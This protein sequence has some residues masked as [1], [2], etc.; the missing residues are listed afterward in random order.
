MTTSSEQIVE[1]LRAA[2][3]ENERLKRRNRELTT[4]TAEPIAIVGISCRFPGGVREPADLW[5][6]VADG[7]DAVTGFPADRGWDLDALYSADRDRPGTTYT[8]SGGFL[9]G[10]ADFDPA[11][12]GISPREALSMDPQQRLL[13]EASWEAVEHARIDPLSLRGSKTGVFAG[14]VYHD[15]GSWLSRAPEDLEGYLSTGISG[16]V[17][18]G[19]ISYTLGLAGP[20]VTVDTACSSSLVALHL[21]CESL[22]RGECTLALAGGVAVLATPMMFVE[23]ARQGALSADG[24]CR[25]FA[26]GADGTALSE[27]VG[28]L[29]VERLSDARRRGHPVLA[30]VRGSAINQDGASSGLTAPNGPAQQ[31]VI[32][33]ALA[34]AGLAASDVDAV[35]AHGTGTRLGDPIE[36]QALLATYGQDR[37]ADRPLW[38]GSV[39]SNLGHTQA[40]AG[41]ASIVKLVEA[42]RHGVLPKSLHLD[43]PTPQVDWTAGA[44]SLL[45]E[46]VPWPET[47]RP[48]R[49]GVSSFGISGTNAHVVLEQAPADDEPGTHTGVVPWVVTGATEAAAQAQA[50]RLRAFAAARPELSTSD[51]GLSLL[52]TRPARD[53]RI[54]VA[55]A[56]RQALLAG[57]ASA[58][59]RRVGGGR[60]AFLFTGQGG[61]RPG[62]GRELYERYPVY[63]RAFDEACAAAG[64]DRDLVLGGADLTR[65]DLA[66]PAI[67]A[68]EVALYRLF[69]AWGARPDRLAG[70]SIGEVAAAHVAGVLSL[71]DAG[72]LIAAR[73]RLLAS[74]PETGAMV[75]IQATEAEVRARLRDFTGVAAGQ[76]A[77]VEGRV[78]SVGAADAGGIAAEGGV[79]SRPADVVAGQVAEVEVRARLDG[80]AGNNSAGIAGGQAAGAGVRDD[81]TGVVDI[82]AVQAAGAE[83]RSGPA[84]VAAGQVAEVEVRARLDGVAGNNSAGIAAGQATGA[85]VRDYLTGVVDIAA[86]NGPGSVVVS[87]AAEAVAA[88]A[89]HFAEQ[90]RRTKR[91]SV[92]H[93]FHSPLVEPVLDEFRAVVAS[94][95]YE[96]PRIPIVSTVSPSADL[97]TPGYWVEHVRATVRFADAVTALAEAGV[98]TCVELGPDAVLSAMGAECADLTFVPALR[99]GE[100]EATTVAAALG[101][102]RD[103]DWPGFFAGARTVDLPGYAFQRE[104]F[105]LEHDRPHDDPWRYRITWP[106]LPDRPAAPPSGTWLVL[107][108]ADGDPWADDIREALDVVTVTLDTGLDRHAV[109]ERIRAALGETTPAGVLSLLAAATAPHPGHPGIPAGLALTTTALQALRVDA[110][111]WLVTRSAVAV[112]PDEV[113]DPDQ[114]RIWGFGQVAALEA[115]DRDLRLADVA[116]DA[117]PRFLALL[118]AA[119]EHRLAA[120][121]HRLAAG[122]HRPAAGEHRPAAGR[123]GLF[124][125]YAEDQVAVRR[126]GVHGRRLVRATAPATAPE[127]PWRPRGT[128]LVTGG[129]GA[130]GAHVARWLAETGAAHLVLTSRRGLD[131]PGAPALRDELTALGVRVTVAACD[132]ADRAA[133]AALLAEHPPNAVVHAAGVA[134][135]T[136]VDATD[137]AELAR[138][139]A[140][141]TRGAAHLDELL[142]G[143]DLDAFVL[144]SSVSGVWGADGQAAYA[145]ANAYLDALARRRRARGLPATAIAWG[146]WGET[147]M[148]TREGVEAHLR[149]RGLAAMPPRRAVAAVQHAL[150]HGDT[151]VVVADVDWAAFT[152]G[153]RGR[154][155]ADLPEARQSAAKA[156]TTLAARLAELPE[157]DRRPFVTELVHRHVAAVLGHRAPGTV[158]PGRAFRELGFDSLTAVDLRDRLNGDTGLRLSA[159]VVFDH[160]DVAALAAELHRAALGTVPDETPTT[161]ER[162]DEPI[163][164]IGVA[165]RFP[166]GADT[167]DRFWDLVRSGRDAV[168]GFPEDR[169]WDLAALYDPEPG[170]P[171][172]TYTRSG[173]FLGDAA[174]FDAAFFGISPREARAM[175]PQQRVLLETSWEAVERAG[176]DPHRLR[177]SRT[178]VFAGVTH[179]GYGPPWD[180]AAGAAA[181]HL[182]TGIASSVVAGRVAYTF[183]LE[184]P[185]LS[186]DTSCSSSLVAL[187]LA[188]ESLRRGESTLALA[189]G[190]TVMSNPGAFVEFGRQRGLAPDGRCKP[191]AAAADGTAWGEGAGVLLLERLSD[192]ERHGHEVLAVLRGSAVNSDGASN[193]LTAPNGPSQQRVIRAALANAGLSASDVDVVEAHGTGTTLG[194]PI[195]AQALLATY[196]QD[197]PADRPLWLGSVKSN[198]GHTQAAAGVAG[199]IKMVEALRHGVLPPTLHLDEP[200]PRVD[201]SAGAVRLLDG[202]V[203]WPAGDRPRRAGV[204]SFGMS[205]TNAHVVLEQAPVRARPGAATV[206]ATVPLALSAKTG[207]ALAAQAAR[208]LSHVDG[209]DVR[210]ADLGASLAARPLFDHRAVVLPGVD[211]RA[212]LQAL[213]TGRRT[214]SVLSGVA[215]AAGRTVFVFPG[216]GGQWAGMG[217]RL[218]RES[219]VFA[220]RMAE[221]DAALGEFVDWSVTGVLLG[222]PGAPGLDAVDVVQ[223]ALFATMV[224]LARLWQSAGV[225]PAAVVGH[226][227]GEIAAACVAGALSLSDAA[228]VVALRSKALGELAG[229]G[230]MVSV[231]L[232]GPAAAALLA[233]WDDRLALAA[234]NGPSSVVVSGDPEALQE[235]VARCESDGVRARAVPVDYA[236][237]SAHVERI[238]DRLLSELA[239]IRPRVP[240]IAFWS[241]VT[242]ERLDG[243]A[244][245]AG[246]WYRNLRQTVLLE[247]VVERLAEAGHTAFVEVGPHPVLLAAVLETVEA[248]GADA[249]VTG[250]LRRGD[251]SLDRFAESVAALHVRGVAVDWRS[252]FPDAR[253]VP[254][255]TYPFERERFWLDRGAPAAGPPASGHPLLGAVVAVAGR[256]EVAFAG[257]LGVADRPWLADHAVHGAILFP[258]TGFL[259]LASAAGDRTGCATVEELTLEAPLVLPATGTVETQVL[260]G[261]PDDTGRRVVAVHSRPEGGEWTRHAT[262]VLSAAEPPAAGPV[263]WPPPGAVPVDL[264]GFYDHLADRGYGYGP[265]FRGLRA[266]WRAGDDVYAEVRLPDGCPAESFGLHP[267]LLDAA[268]HAAGLRGAPDGLPFSWTGYTRFAAEATGVRVRLSPA[269]DGIAVTVV[270]ETGEPVARIDALVTRPAPELARPATA[271]GLHRL[272][273]VPVPGPGAATTWT[274]VSTVDELAGVS[275]DLVAGFAVEDGDPATTVR[276]TTLRALE[277]LQAFLGDEHRAGTDRLVLHTRGAV[278]TG[279]GELPDPAQ[280]AVWGLVRSAQSEHPGRFVLVDDPAG[281]ALGAALALGEPQVAVR[282]GEFRVPRLA[283]LAPGDATP[284]WG[285][286]TVLV[287]GASGLIGGLVARRL[288]THHGVTR[289]ALLGR[290]GADTPE[291]AALLAGLGAEATWHACDV[292][293]RAALAGVV[294]GLPDLTAVVHS[295][296]AL[297][298]GVVT[299]LTP[300]RLETVLR[301]KLDAALALHE[302]TK[303]RD[304]AAFLLFSS[305]SGLL[306]TAG[307]AG[308]AASNAFLDAYTQRL[309]AAGVPAK[310]LAWGLWAEP[311]AMSGGLGDVYLARGA[312]IGLLPLSSEQGL[313][314]FDA[315][316]TVDEAVV[317]PVRV[318]TAV[319]R[320]AEAGVPP[321]LRGLAGPH[322]RRAADP[323]HRP[324][325]DGFARRM[326]ALSQAERAEALLGLVRELT[327]DA[328]GLPSAAAVRD[329]RGFLEVGFDSLIAVE[330]RN[331]LSAATGVKLP[332]TLVF[333]HPSPAAVAEFAAA[334][335]A[336]NGEDTA[337]AALAGLDGVAAVLRSAGPEARA[338]I[339]TRLQALVADPGAAPDDAG[340]DDL[341]GASDE[342]LFDLIDNDFGMA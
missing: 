320:T 218:L 333:D 98:T 275:G 160:P 21:A 338:R 313:E 181:G 179:Q 18:S 196:G 42:M 146:A 315:A 270:D 300:D 46:P 150:D 138:V 234:V 158:D 144:F 13:L 26:A 297:D 255:P 301:P 14:L 291:A 254:L 65:T 143:T 208:L 7:V 198:I 235:L 94:L 203:D 334:R 32:R 1:A 298:D 241:T 86:V 169:G 142:A 141:K 136:P 173:G 163:A 76:A 67:F 292:A 52:A 162:A 274:E 253:R 236:S 53:H 127:R 70:H 287:T 167:P 331:R 147:G 49:A 209:A 284:V 111:C 62:M 151:A 71:A 289:L 116:A 213:A 8:R 187:H 154:L 183:G 5:R 44:V 85:E 139:A 242:G 309:R 321:V 239:P 133:L 186:V 271:D 266:A 129:T 155:L 102:V 120:G 261:E 232:P 23:F 310:A 96:R 339:V 264:T 248:S 87:G 123:D 157:A 286:G 328:L 81:L 325:P 79:R 323:V 308:Y 63:A 243:P 110:P 90:G 197:R 221:C 164:V 277:L 199:V 230:G 177:G 57:L 249:V 2:L 159:T 68:L 47:G 246:Y 189:G 125:T 245:D 17:A 124:G 145:A 217:A 11:F 58:R 191:F 240:G 9:D 336:G 312:R 73:G 106:T 31:Q 75:A 20:A 207:T 59:P 224:S 119:G 212:A 149:R 302:V 30:V 237:H 168:S 314:L 38:L 293:D 22:R 299:A 342:E 258:G 28:M 229:Q 330:F 92:S 25:S 250:T 278:A 288:V 24:R 326:R 105:W 329:D 97:A 290:R 244:T 108:P 172:R 294:A 327:A 214:T 192:A 276:R 10:V 317:V 204:S 296:G 259:E 12:F 307:Q 222:E 324:D 219:E 228:R 318:D 15:Y 201:W 72:T 316:L 131:A 268:L 118:G 279:A 170:V 165:C 319:L 280:A 91:L 82:A 117:V 140:A 103:A 41:I 205:G 180:S 185:A 211:P 126:D 178:G 195:E 216:Q 34:A 175:D 263:E 282:D 137:A 206:P 45:A 340:S 78:R 305:A 311:S 51:I 114:A 80:V 4:A 33:S 93:A 283:R 220:K 256:A 43:E 272:T 40:A 99:A 260:V 257:R 295:A 56:D 174:G 101:H 35:E 210:W 269:G 251:D 134:Q 130:L 184:G 60:P 227:Q 48:R 36:A 112:G 262:G 152:A 226:S 171:G 61:Q 77:G 89:A 273:W 100:P 166:G 115:P 194:D 74:L 19:R 27:G 66:Q 190:V 303:N 161:P 233:R 322:R 50:A 215:T 88:I 69:E 182:L 148:S 6:V 16:S 247:P 252:F 285:G 337:A 83:V 37:P 332:S 109:A 223:P 281:D 335:L 132:V 29:L 64:L 341:A 231:A 304:L 122:E 135:F 113:P 3:K 39:K 54:V 104:R 238:R 128:V 188:A 153:R 107:V 156:T 193:G 84:D 265:A 121:E 202:A 95:D 225:E 200:T 176:I 267:A 55:G 306:G